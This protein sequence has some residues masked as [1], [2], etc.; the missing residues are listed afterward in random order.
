MVL[1]LEQNKVCVHYWLVESL[2]ESRA[3]N[4]SNAKYSIGICK[5]CGEKKE[6]K[7]IADLGVGGGWKS[8]HKFAYGR[9]K[10]Q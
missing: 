8:K 2:Q 7:N 1:L 4:K 3:R 5:Y 6:F 10:K 9:K